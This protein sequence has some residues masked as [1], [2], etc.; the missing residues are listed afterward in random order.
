MNNV[1]KSLLFSIFIS[2]TV[3]V[4]GAETPNKISRAEPS[5]TSEYTIHTPEYGLVQ[6]RTFTIGEDCYTERTDRT[7]QL[8]PG[9]NGSRVLVQTAVKTYYLVRASASNRPNCVSPVSLNHVACPF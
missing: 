1:I 9:E 4:N 7:Y 2:A 5:Y 6:F 8:V 3:S